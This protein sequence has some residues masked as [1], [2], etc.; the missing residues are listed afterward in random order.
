MLFIAALLSSLLLGCVC[1]QKIGDMDIVYEWV[2]VEYDWPEDGGLMKARYEAQGLYVPHNNVLAGIK[3]YKN[4]TYVTVP[5]W[6]HGVPSTLNKVVHTGTRALLQ[7][8]PNWEMQELGNCRSLQYV[9]SM[10]ID[11]KCGWM[12]IIDVGRVN[13]LESPDETG[14]GPV[15]LCPPKLV[16]YDLNRDKIVRVH[17]FDNSV[18]SHTA[19]FL[20]DIVVDRIHRFAYIS[21][22]HGN[23]SQGGII[24][25]S[26]DEDKARLFYGPS[27]AIDP[28]A[29]HIDINNQSY[30]FRTPS[31]GIALGQDGTTLFYCALS[32]Y[33][34]YSLDSEL[35]R[36][37]HLP[38]SDIRH[39]V[40]RLGTKVSQSDGL[41]FSSGRK[42]YFG[43]ESENAVYYWDEQLDGNKFEPATEK[44]LVSNSTTMEWIDTFAFD[45]QGYLWFTSNRLDKFI[46]GELRFS[47][48]S[49]PNFRIIRVFVND[50][51]YLDSAI[52]NFAHC[53]T[54][55]PMPS[56][57]PAVA[58]PHATQTVPLG[59][60]YRPLY[61]WKYIDYNW[62]N[63][64]A[65][66]VS[67]ALG[68]FIQP[69]NIPMLVANIQ[70]TTFL[71]V[72]RLKPGV[73]STLNTLITT[74]SGEVLLDPYP[75][76]AMQQLGNCTALQSVEGI[77]I[78][79]LCN[80][81]W[82]VDS[83]RVGYLHHDVDGTGEV[84][85]MSVCPPKLIVFNLTN[86]A[87]IRQYEFSNINVSHL[88]SAL[89][90]VVIDKVHQVAY[91]A[92]GGYNNNGTIGGI[93]VYDFRTNRA[94]QVPTPLPPGFSTSVLFNDK[95]YNVTLPMGTHSLALL[96]D[97]SRLYFSSLG[98]HTLYSVA[99]D[100]LR[101]FNVPDMDIT[102]NMQIVGDT[103]S[104]SASM[105]FGSSGKLYFGLQSTGSVYVLSHPP[106]SGDSSFS[107]PHILVGK[108]SNVEW[109]ESLTF[110]NNGKLLMVANR[111]D[112]FIT[113]DIGCRTPTTGNNNF[114]VLEIDIDID[115]SYIDSEIV[116]FSTCPVVPVKDNSEL[117]QRTVTI[118]TVTIASLLAVATAV[119]LALI[120]GGRS[121]ILKISGKSEN[122]D[123]VGWAEPLIDEP[124]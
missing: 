69:N 73:P 67:K 17:V 44:K 108:L 20:N 54:A 7:P 81:L 104:P 49:D 68:N 34:V 95:V 117:A 66:I 1:S 50:S 72:P 47:N 83:G 55:Q 57:T 71:T 65:K 113:G 62:P 110:A 97:T 99:T 10:E 39:Q 56:P 25:Y 80:Q 29:E 48:P 123:K 74:T 89:D 40:R 53:P 58:H 100:D 23:N 12:W 4:T 86:N 33:T 2:S 116:Q 64:H 21:D 101:D 106:H 75:N 51:S 13:I 16:I 105:I 36:E 96:P 102:S 46:S 63:N 5:R 111:F 52:A 94:R 41:V 103:V 88:T 60:S 45:E 92:N 31:D 107:K 9:Q 24:A 27:T 112:Q 124:F 11:A 114:Y 43:V 119:F 6:K 35:L 14:L 120:F 28:N 37:F 22:A 32:S 115:K 15:N 91:I 122:E 77:E 118:F 26:F 8:F 61:W 76:W 82:V 93:V 78:D 109:P 38:L 121:S 85:I 98:G 87:V 30:T 84:R 18:A 70:N 79:Q 90:N 19:N 59:V 42:L 3:I